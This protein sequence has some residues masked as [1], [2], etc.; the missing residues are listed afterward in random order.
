VFD[1]DLLIFAK[2]SEEEGT[3]AYAYPC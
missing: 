2:A 3:L 1:T